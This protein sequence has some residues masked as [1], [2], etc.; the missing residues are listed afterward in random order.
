MKNEPDVPLPPTANEGDKYLDIDN[1]K[2]LI[3]R[4]GVW[5][6]KNKEERHGDT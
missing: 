5:V 6:D 4:D 1:G 2:V 3:F